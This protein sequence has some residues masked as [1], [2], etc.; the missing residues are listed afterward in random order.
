MVSMQVARPLLRGSDVTLSFIK[1]PQM[2][3]STW[4]I[5]LAAKGPLPGSAASNRAID[6]FG[7]DRSEIFEEWGGYWRR[8]FGSEL[9]GGYFGR[10]SLRSFHERE[11]L[12]FWQAEG[13]LAIAKD[14][15]MSK[16]KE[17]SKK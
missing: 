10:L 17:K 4:A 16:A 6:I 8:N 13:G 12:R 15:W 1:N 11:P 5:R 3:F 14:P 7:E 9:E 2:A